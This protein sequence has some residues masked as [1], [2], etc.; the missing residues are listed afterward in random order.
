MP[1]HQGERVAA[2]KRNRWLYLE[3]VYDDYHRTPAGR[4][5]TL[6]HDQVVRD[7]QLDED[8]ASRICDYLSDAGLI[9]LTGGGPVLKIT[10]SGIDY[11]EDALLKPEAPT[12]HFPPLSILIARDIRNSQIQH[13]TVSSSQSVSLGVPD[14]EQV[15]TLVAAVREHVAKIAEPSKRAEAEAELATLDAQ[16]QSPEPKQRILRESLSSLRSIVEQTVSAAAAA[17]IAQVLLRLWGL[18]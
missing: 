16:L 18:G 3:Y 1:D 13:G 12:E 6:A 17:P 15:R 2:I 10:I 4:I 8:E 7:L 5:Q 14:F 11:V 9:E